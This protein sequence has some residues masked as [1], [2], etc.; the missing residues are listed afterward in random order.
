[1]VLF[2][3]LL[4]APALPVPTGGL[5]H[6]LE[7][8]AMLLAMQ[9]AIGRTAVWI[10]ARWQ[11]RTL[12]GPKSDRFVERLLRLISWLE[13]R[14]RR[15]GTILLNGRVGN[16]ILGTLVFIFS[17][18]AF[19]APPF[20]MLDTLPALGVVVLSVGVLT[21]DS[22]I[23]GIGIAVGAVGVALVAVLGHVAFRGIESLL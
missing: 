7:V 10:P 5:T 23:A 22:L 14:S 12:V 11:S 3:I 19:L 8:V 16:A 13:R 15:R 4:S 1:M 6:V 2:V 20:S 9:L 18:A 17:L 21:E